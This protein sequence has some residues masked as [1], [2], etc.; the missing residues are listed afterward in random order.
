M[1]TKF[2]FLYWVILPL[3]G[4]VCWL[5]FYTVNEPQ[6]VFFGYAE[7]K[8]TQI[9]LDEAARVKSVYVTPGQK[10]AKDQMLVELDYH[11]T[12]IDLA[13]TKHNVEQA[14]R[15]IIQKRSEV[16]TALEK[17][18]SE[19]SEKLAALESEFAQAKS[20]LDYQKSLVD[21]SKLSGFQ[22]PL[23]HQLASLQKEIYTTGL[24]YDQLISSYQKMLTVPSPEEEE[25]AG[26]KEKMRLLSLEKNKTIIRAPFDG[27]VGNINCKNSEYIDAH[28]TMLSFYEVRPTEAL[29][30]VHESM[31][32]TVKIGDE[33]NVSSVMHPG[34]TSRGVITGLGHRIIEIP[35]RLRKIPE[36][37][38]YGMEVY[39]RL[40]NGNA[41][42]QKEALKF[43]LR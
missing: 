24:A 14:S 10:V 34:H 28:T 7:N 12:D 8:E 37:K 15:K 1:T 32:L 19:K 31:S 38:T 36:Y 13:M 33:V 43:T 40:E 5:F 4:S 18:R 20:K 27:L 26:L 16:L 2:N 6:T 21:A 23:E 41:F 3:I 22:N 42:L 25:V 35:E 17:A 9:S 39:I 30:Y 11:S 29:A